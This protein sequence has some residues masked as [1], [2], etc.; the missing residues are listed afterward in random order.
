MDKESKTLITNITILI[1]AV[2]FIIFQIATICSIKRLE[3]QL[4][5][6]CYQTYNN[7]DN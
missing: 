6:Q 1:L 4:N 5:K 7:R 2:S 3:N